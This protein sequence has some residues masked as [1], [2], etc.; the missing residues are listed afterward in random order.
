M[1]PPGTIDGKTAYEI[2]KIED[3]DRQ[4]E[5]AQSIIAEGMK[6]V[7][8]REVVSTAR[9]DSEA[10]IKAIVTKVQQ[11]PVYAPSI[12]FSDAEYQQ[13]MNK[14]KRTMTERNIRPGIKADVEIEP[15]IRAE[16]IKVVDVFRRTLG[17]FKDENAKREGFETIDEFKDSWM[18][19]YGVWDDSELVYVVMFA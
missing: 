10:S 17:R 4:Y 15:L 5:V 7:K 19:K 16:P 18:Q 14:K 3:K 12:V 8:A 13:I 9:F 11:R 1:T 2:S 6:G